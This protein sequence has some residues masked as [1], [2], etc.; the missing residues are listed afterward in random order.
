MCYL[1]M[2]LEIRL[3]EGRRNGER[4]RE[5]RKEEKRRNPIIRLWYDFSLNI[6]VAIRKSFA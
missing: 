4:G 1:D 3:G 2:T 5:R 6:I